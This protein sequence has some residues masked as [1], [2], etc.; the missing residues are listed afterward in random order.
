MMIAVIGTLAW[1]SSD[2]PLMARYTSTKGPPTGYG[3]G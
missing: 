1:S 3:V 2:L